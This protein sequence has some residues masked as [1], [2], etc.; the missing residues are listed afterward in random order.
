MVA[1]EKLYFLFLIFPVGF[2]T[3]CSVL[4]EENSE[5]V[6]TEMALLYEEFTFRSV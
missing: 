2:T 4:D 3:T 6:V 5:K 1:M